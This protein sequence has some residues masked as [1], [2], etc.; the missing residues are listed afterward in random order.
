MCINKN[1][2][3]FTQDKYPIEN[4]IKDSKGNIR[5]VA[6]YNK[7]GSMRCDFTKCDYICDWENINPEYEINKDTFTEDFMNETIDNLKEFLKII[8]INSYSYTLENII[9][10]VHKEYKPDLNKEYIYIALDK[11]I[12]NKDIVYDMYNRLGNIIYRDGLYIYQPMEIDD[13]NIPYYY[14]SNRLKNKV[15]SIGLENTEELSKIKSTISKKFIKKSIKK[16]T[17]KKATQENLV[18]IQQKI[19]K[20]LSYSNCKK[21]INVEYNNYPKKTEEKPTINIPTQEELILVYQFYK[22]DRLS[23]FEKEVLLSK[24]LKSIIK[25]NNKPVNDKI[26][27]ILYFDKDQIMIMINHMPFLKRDKQLR[28]KN[29]AAEFEGEDF[30]NIL[31]LNVKMGHKFFE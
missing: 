3:I 28:M 5:K 9:K 30:L 22:I 18:L 23:D 15:Y 21:Y 11:L 29:E 8:F 25:N 12:K 20:E 26:L 14:R 17:A 10:I 2:N 4:I 24:S 31:E 19:E 6:L 16:V 1:T 13:L 27:V 7:D